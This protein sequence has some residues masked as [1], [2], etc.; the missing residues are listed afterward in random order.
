MYTIE[1]LKNATNNIIDLSNDD[2]EEIY[3]AKW[4]IENKLREDDPSYT[5]KTLAKFITDLNLGKYIFVYDGSSIPFSVYRG[6]MFISSGIEEG[7]I[8]MKQVFSDINYDL[9]SLKKFD[10]L[11][12]M[13]GNTYGPTYFLIDANVMTL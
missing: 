7:T 6:Y 8:K 4:K 3:V 11:S 5:K 1:E 12:L 2:P 10:P 13:S 9:S